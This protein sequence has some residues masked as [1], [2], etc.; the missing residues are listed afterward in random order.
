MAL[1]GCSSVS[2]K[3]DPHYHQQLRCYATGADIVRGNQRRQT[4]EHPGL[5]PM[6]VPD[7]VISS[8]LAD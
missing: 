6:Q 8:G 3:P 7:A 4:I 2:A 5:A 1:S